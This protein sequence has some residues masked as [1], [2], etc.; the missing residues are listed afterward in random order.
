MHSS[1]ELAAGFHFGKW[2]IKPEDGSLTSDETTLRLEPL[3]M[4]LLVFLC[5]RAGR[6]VSKD[7]ILAGVWQGRFVSDDTIKASFY[8]L[9]KA[10]GDEP[11]NPR[12]IETLPKR[13]YRVLLHPV[14]LDKKSG[15]K[16]QPSVAD[17]LYRKGTALLSGQPAV[18]AMK[19]ARLYFERA[20]EAAPDHAAS[21]AALAQTYIHLVALGIASGRELLPRAKALAARSAE[22]APRFA[23]AHVVLGAAR[24]LHGWDVEAAE[25][26]LRL[27][28]TL[29]DRDPAAR[30]WYAK[31]LSF[32]GRHQEAIAESRCA[33]QLDPLSLVARRDLAETFFLARSYEEAIVE[34]QRLVE[35]AGQAPEVLLGVA[36]IYYVSGNE[37]RAFESVSSGFRLLGTSQ[38]V[39]DQTRQ[40]F[41]SGGMQ[42][43][44]RLWADLLERQAAMGQ[45]TIDLVFLYSLLNEKD[46]A[47]KLIDAIL[48]DFHPAALLV[49]SSPL[50]DPMRSDERYARILAQMALPASS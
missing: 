23:K 24:M 43:V 45:K 30:S 21:A 17:E 27:A 11:R 14:P 9:R 46:S 31:L 33:L 6:V 16:T 1:S 48:A 22:L 18:S 44:L 25:N 10:L 36:W 37:K 13:G 42:R 4:E 32:T 34:A 2:M 41:A 19:Q 28:I 5:T 38:E 35:M 3:L 15:D 49:P 29:D 7:E 47:F 26:E 50:F 40:A 20:I 39:L 8:Q 12:F